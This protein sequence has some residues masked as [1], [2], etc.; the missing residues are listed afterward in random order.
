MKYLQNGGLLLTKKFPSTFYA[1]YDMIEK[2]KEIKPLY[3]S[4]LK[5]FVFVL[6]INENDSLFYTLNEEKTKLDKKVDS[7]I[8]KFALTSK[9]VE[10]IEP[11]LNFQGYDHEKQTDREEDVIDEV[12]IQQKI[13]L[14]SIKNTGNPIVPGIADFSYFSTENAFIILDKLVERSKNDESKKVLQYLK[15]RLT[16][17]PNYPK[18]SDGYKLS[19]ISMENASSYVQIIDA[20]TGEFTLDER[21]HAAMT[22]IAQMIRLFLQTGI[23]HCDAHGGNILTARNETYKLAGNNNPSSM[24]VKIIDFGRFINVY[25]DLAF[26]VYTKQFAPPIIYFLSNMLF[27]KPPRE[28]L[29]FDTLLK[30]YEIYIDNNTK[31]EMKKEKGEKMVNKLKTLLLIILNVDRSYNKKN[32]GVELIQSSTIFKYLKIIHIV[33]EGL[34]DMKMQIYDTKDNEFQQKKYLDIIEILYYL[35]KPKKNV[36]NVGK[37]SIDHFINEQRFATIHDEKPDI[38]NRNVKSHITP[39]DDNLLIVQPSKR[40]MLSKLKGVFTRKRNGG[41][42]R[43][44]RKI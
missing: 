37:K 13:Y 35:M 32:F 8:L 19:M 9:D 20:F 12:Y 26:P 28:S 24:H 33:N 31:D 3:M 34:E 43:N 29:V 30:D 38:H 23:V 27:Q 7:L 2:A 25:D 1:I 18:D 39:P 14:E 4:S 15:L 22:T 41:K 6:N 40:P 17:H 21:K 16:E 5:G 42:K 11:A 44:T 10:N 36:D